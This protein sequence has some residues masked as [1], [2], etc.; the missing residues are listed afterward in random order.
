MENIAI[1]AKC[2]IQK[3]LCNSVRI[4]GIKQPRI[5]K[6]CLIEQMN[7]GDETISDAWWMI[8]MKQLN[9]NESINAIKARYNRQT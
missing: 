9:D 3:E 5:C 2:G 6:E 8:Q 4:D 1:C 7:T